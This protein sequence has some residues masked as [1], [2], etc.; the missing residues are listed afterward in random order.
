MD[1]ILT[2]GLLFTRIALGFQARWF[3]LLLASESNERGAGRT[4]DI[5]HEASFSFLKI[6][7]TCCARQRQDYY[8][9]AASVCRSLLFTRLGPSSGL[10]ITERGLFHGE[11]L[12]TLYVDTIL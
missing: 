4:T 10:L 9:A 7:V 11:H 5:F 2:R 8:S 1:T 12:T 3:S 6:L